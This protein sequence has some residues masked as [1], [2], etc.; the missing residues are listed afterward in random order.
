MEELKETL[1]RLDFLVDKLNVMMLETC[2]GA[3]LWTDDYDGEAIECDGHC[4]AE[5]ISNTIN[6][7]RFLINAKQ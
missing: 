5:D 1:E 6:E 7:I 4:L 3:E 2:A